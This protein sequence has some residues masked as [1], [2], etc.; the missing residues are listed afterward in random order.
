MRRFFALGSVAALCALALA[1]RAQETVIRINAAQTLHPVSRY[2][3]GACLEDVNHEVYGGIDSQ[4]I[5]GESFAE[6][7]PERPIQG[8]E[9]FGHWS[10][11]PG[12][13]RV[14]GGQRAKLVAAAPVFAEGEASVE[15]KFNDRGGGNA[16]LI[17]KVSEPGQGPDA[18]NGYEVALEPET[19]RLVLGRHRHNWEFI[20]QVPC[21]FAV[22]RWN[23][24]AVRLHTNALEVLVNGKSITQYQDTEHPLRT[25]AVGLR[26]WQR[27][28]SFRNLVVRTGDQELKYDFACEGDLAWGQGV[29]RQ[30]RPLR[31]GTAE[32][33]FALV[34]QHAFSGPQ[35]QQ[36]TFT[37]GAG[38]IGL[39]NQGLNRWGMNFV[40]GKGYEGFL[41]VCATR[42]TPFFVALESADGAKVY[43]EKR[44]TTGAGDWQRIDFTL[45]PKAADTTG[46]FAIKLK[47][48]G[49]LT[50]GYALLQPGPWGRFQGL[51]V[52]KD[53]AQALV[54]QGI[55]VLR[56]GGSMVNAAGYRWKQMTGPRE[57]RVPYNG[58]W[59]PYSSRGWG[60]LEFLD[61][62]QAAGFLA[63]PDLNLDETPQDL[64]DF[65]EYVN[66]A[67][68]TP[69]GAKRAAAG[70]PQPYHLK[71]L[72]LGNEERVDATYA[73]KFK[74]LAEAIWVKD[75]QLI[76]I[77]GDFAYGKAIKDPFHFSGA[78]SGITTMAAHQQILQLAKQHGQEVWFDVHIG[79]DGPRPDFGGFFS[80]A[81][82]LDQIAAGAKHHLLTFEFN[83]NRHTHRR[84]LGNAAA[85]VQIERDGRIPIATSANCLQPDGQNENDWNQGL[86]FLN[87]A[88]VW[89]QP[90][91]YVTQMFSRHYQPLL[92]QSEALNDSGRLAVSAQRSADGR[93]LVLQV[94]NFSEQ[95]TTAT[96]ELAGF[97]P[98]RAQATVQT[99][100]G[101]LEARNTAYNPKLLTPTVRDWPHGLKDGRTTYTFAP[102]SVTVMQF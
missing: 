17:V 36:L 39:E 50:L 34:Q 85:I 53:V 21:A 61:F 54:G 32:G 14:F 68:T 15:V 77:V 96:L 20:R 19:G 76:L 59:Y 26:T 81:D 62:C 98:R 7:V 60:V 52:R 69:W 16:G 90:P 71:H 63:V 93:T 1:G 102:N 70:H 2:L 83:A 29:S 74:A 65:I 5:F 55:T 23:T 18:F 9:T 37:A 64:A 51:P 75:P 27:D 79:T 82:A 6:P 24:L 49:S 94:V 84:A 35:S 91:G 48:P 72:E 30:W 89:L 25:G 66:G 95:P 44:L 45:K 3:T 56:F 87:P 40:A 99:L 57:R 46:R 13:V 22:D 31:H 41:Y 101:A 8:F 38:E 47:S 12:G 88:R 97:T 28:A 73:T 10:P 11:E 42:P 43:A 67:A 92:V 4:M 58:T 78:A 80:Y 33:E 86:L 100:A